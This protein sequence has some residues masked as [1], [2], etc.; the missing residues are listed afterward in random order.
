MLEKMSNE[1]LGLID[2]FINPV[3]WSKRFEA[4]VSDVVWVKHI[5]DEAN[6]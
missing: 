3:Y 1:Q 6:M 4:F 5:L 2:D